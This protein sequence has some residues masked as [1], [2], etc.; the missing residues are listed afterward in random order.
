RLGLTFTTEG[1]VIKG[2]PAVAMERDARA[3][4]ARLLGA[5]NLPD[6]HAAPA[7][8]GGPGRG[9]P[10]RPG[11]QLTWNRNG[12]TYAETR[13][14]ARRHGSTHAARHHPQRRPC[15]ARQAAARLVRATARRAGLLHERGEAVQRRAA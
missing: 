4:F 3:S 11:R 7:K 12:G 8:A 15:A 10:G 2:N 13:R 1:G 6:P 14:N 5:L 9:G